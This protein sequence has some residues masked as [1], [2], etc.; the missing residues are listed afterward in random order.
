MPPVHS[1]ASPVR[2]GEL[3]ASGKLSLRALCERLQDAAVGGAAALGV[4]MQA[5]AER[6]RAWVLHELRIEVERPA[7]PGELLCVTTWPSGFGRLLAERDFELS[8][9]NEEI[10]RAT[11]RWA[12]VDLAERRAVHLEPAIQ[13]LP[14]GER[15]AAL[16][17]ATPRPRRLSAAAGERRFEVRRSDL[18]SVGHVN[19]TRYVDWLVEGVPDAV[20]DTR[21]ICGIE[22]TF[23]R[24]VRRGQTVV[25]RAARL[26][27]SQEHFAHELLDPEDRR[28]AGA[29]TRWSAAARKLAP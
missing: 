15:R 21:W 12:I 19:H 1:E 7:R 18:D 2:F 8:V 27:G 11:S 6:G 25:S 17:P 20:W 9:G 28:L 23:S 16:A 3:D 5:L 29:V 22:V 4:S 10:A 24:E 13:A 14:L 26:P